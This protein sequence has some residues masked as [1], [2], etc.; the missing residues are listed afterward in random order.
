MQENALVTLWVFTYPTKP[1]DESERSCISY[2]LEDSNCLCFSD[3]PIWTLV[4]FLRC[5]IFLFYLILI[6]SIT[7][8]CFF[9]SLTLL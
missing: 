7:S 2:L 8:L 3:F 5:G 9:L 4:L 6:L 1:G